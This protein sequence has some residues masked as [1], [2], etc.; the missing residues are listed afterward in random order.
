MPVADDLISTIWER[1]RIIWMSRLWAI[2][3][4]TGV[5]SAGDIVHSGSTFAIAILNARALGPTRFGLYSLFLATTYIGSHMADLALSVGMVKYASLHHAD[6]EERDG[7]FV[8]GLRAKLIVAVSV[9][10]IGVVSLLVLWD[11]YW[12]VAS[13]VSLGLVN[14]G[15]L[16]LT[17]YVRSVMQALKRFTSL[18]LYNALPSV[19][20][21]ICVFTLFATHTVSL[22]VL[23]L[24]GCVSHLVTGTVGLKLIPGFTCGARLSLHWRELWRFCRWLFLSSMIY[25]AIDR[26]ALFLITLMAGEQSAGIYSVAF[27]LAAGFAVVSAAMQK[28]LLPHVSAYTSVA[29]FDRFIKTLLRAIPLMVIAWLG[30]LMLSGALIQFF[31]GQAYDAAMPVFG[32]ISVSYLIRMVVGPL[33]LIIWAMNKQAFLVLLNSLQLLLMIGLYCLVVP[34]WGAIGAALAFSISDG[35]L[36]L[37]A[38]PVYTRHLM[39]RESHP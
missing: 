12:G 19:A 20:H 30:I 13:V 32:I 39:R 28:V 14:S 21:V 1:T 18:A 7:V 3:R 15:G 36:A 27:Q 25:Q 10:M 9:Q 16:A 33:G 11:G 24:L 23:L 5:V 31:F 2:V 37:I 8:A 4:N 29:Q 35:L 38:V 17:Y 22:P 6:P 26:S 34:A